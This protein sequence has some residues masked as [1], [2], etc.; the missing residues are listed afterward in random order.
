MHILKDLSGILCTQGK[1]KHFKK[2]L[3]MFHDNHD[4][5][6]YNGW[7]RWFQFELMQALNDNDYVPFAEQSFS[8]D[9]RSSKI[10]KTNR[11]D[12]I[13]TKYNHLTDYQIGIEIKVHPYM[14]Y[15]IAGILTDFS[16]F[17]QIHEKIW[18]LRGVIG[19]A[20]YSKKI[21]DESKKS[22]YKNFTARLIEKHLAYPVD[23]GDWS[24]LLFGWDADKI[25]TEHKER[26]KSYS[27][28]FAEL[29]NIANEFEIS[30][31]K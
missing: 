20:I 25:K 16:G 9:Q 22:K 14:S 5:S 30:I 19:I 29:K 18:N 27:V 2:M 17:T 24:F 3:K 10:K 6:N 8:K 31:K 12:I 13:C 26:K 11:L 15:S 21:T 7:E 1:D 4:N 23:I 28:Y